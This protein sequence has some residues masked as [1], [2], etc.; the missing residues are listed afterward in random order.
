MAHFEKLREGAPGS[1]DATRC[2]MTQHTPS[3]DVPDDT[4]PAFGA[5]ALHEWTGHVASVL[6]GMTHALN[7][8]AA[9]LSAVVELSREDD[10][11]SAELSSI[12]STE[13]N[14]VRNLAH[15]ARVI[16]IARGASEAFSPRDAANEAMAVLELHASHRDHPAVIGQTTETPV[17]VPKWMFVRSLIAL[18]ASASEHCDAGARIEIVEDGDSI[19]TRA[20]GV[21]REC[22]NVSPYAAE[23]ARA[24]GGQPLSEGA[25]GCGFRIPTLAAIRRREVR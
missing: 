19:V 13:L 10:G 17:R 6:R 5:E 16:G 20:Q 22:A 4:A 21:N 11:D 15:I 24:M 23:L 18:A 3:Q 9:A 2:C 1:R 8:R 25:E 12:L 7:N 14:R